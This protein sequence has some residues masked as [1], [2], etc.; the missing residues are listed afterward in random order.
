MDETGILNEGEIFCPVLND[1]FH[2][3]II[4]GQDVVIKRSPALHP[5]DIQLV[6]AVDV[7]AGSPLRR[8]HNCVIFSKRVKETSLACLAVVT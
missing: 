2:R 6:N 4:I 5:G 7:L 1:H 8:L 3:E